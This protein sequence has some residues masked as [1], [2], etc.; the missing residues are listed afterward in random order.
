[1]KHPSSFA[2]L[3]GFRFPREVIAYEVW[4]NHRCEIGFTDVFNHILLSRVEY[5]LA[6]RGGMDSRAAI[7]LWVNRLGKQLYNC[8]RRD[9]PE[10]DNKWHLRECLL[11]INGTKH[12]VWRAIDANGD[13]LNILVQSH[14]YSKADKRFF[15][16]PIAQYGTLS[17]VVTDK[18]NSYNKS[19]RTLA[20]EA[21]HRAA[22]GLKSR[23]ESAHRPTRK[24]DKI[25]RRFISPRQAQRFLQD[26]E[27]VNMHFR[28]RRYQLST[29]SYRHAR[30]DA[31]SLWEEY[32]VEMI[33]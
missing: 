6:E 11:T 8:I 7:R 20:P 3:K 13:V 25:M 1:M 30:A 31:F 4:A 5:L 12:W 14:I 19:V 22:K 32:T 28:S 15:V 26:H 16:K 17:V 10:P 27:Q 21:D 18:L 29:T 33:A 9:R 2:R 23:I 24:R